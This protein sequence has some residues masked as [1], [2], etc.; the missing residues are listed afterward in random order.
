[1][2]HKATRSRQSRAAETARRVTIPHSS[3]SRIDRSR[4]GSALIAPD[5][6]WAR[7]GL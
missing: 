1:M 2:T 5:D 4:G 6:F 3:W 7:L